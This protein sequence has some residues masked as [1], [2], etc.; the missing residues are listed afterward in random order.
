MKKIVIFTFILFI[1]L[2]FGTWFFKDQL[3]SKSSAQKISWDLLYKLDYKTGQMPDDVKAID[4][5][6]VRMAGFIVPLSDDYTMLSE[7]L[8]VPDAQACIHVPPP[9]PNLIIHVH[10]K[11]PL[12]RDKVTN[13]AWVVGTIK[14][15][16]SESIHGESSYRMEG[17]SMEP[18]VF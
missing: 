15:Q 13:P 11:E 5:Q 12:P 9:P 3:K 17:E 8:L 6:R 1:T 7:F 14:I 18:F 16:I 4:G 2:I 10:L